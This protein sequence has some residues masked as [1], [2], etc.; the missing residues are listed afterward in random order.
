VA[1]EFGSRSGA[2]TSVYARVAAL[3]AWGKPCACLKWWEKGTAL[4]LYLR[5]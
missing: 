4:E 3:L 1:P 5:G 2:A